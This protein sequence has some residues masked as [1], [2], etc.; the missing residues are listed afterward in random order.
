M[1]QATNED[2]HDLL[3]GRI[4]RELT[5]LHYRGFGNRALPSQSRE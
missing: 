3:E 1:S 4:A 5:S 2:G